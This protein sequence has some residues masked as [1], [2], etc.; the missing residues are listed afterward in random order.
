MVESMEAEIQHEVV[1]IGGGVAGL[2]AAKEL[3][4]QGVTNICLVE[5]Q[6][7]LGGRVKQ[8]TQATPLAQ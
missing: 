2:S 8:V 4:A 6:W 1:I 3:I 7:R 5:A